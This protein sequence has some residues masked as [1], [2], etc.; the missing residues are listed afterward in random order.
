MADVGLVLDVEFHQ[1]VEVAGGRI[2][3]GGELGVREL[4][5]HLVGLAELAFDL[6]EERDH[7]R[8]RAALGRY[9][10]R[11]RARPGSG[12]QMSKITLHWTGWIADR[13]RCG[14]VGTGGRTS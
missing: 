2:D 11:T 7:A 8:L 13:R 4:V 10:C 12:G 9:P 14:T 6:D 1:Q 3:L 5:C